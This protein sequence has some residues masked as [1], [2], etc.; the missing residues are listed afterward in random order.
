[1]DAQL[2]VSSCRYCGYDFFCVASESVINVD[3]VHSNYLFVYSSQ[4][5]G[6]Q[7]HCFC[8]SLWTV[9]ARFYLSFVN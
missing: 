6:S 4:V 5:K 2:T 1:M 8:V 7:G 9:F 3:K